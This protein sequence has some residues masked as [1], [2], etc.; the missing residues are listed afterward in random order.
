MKYVRVTAVNL[1]STCLLYLV[2]TAANGQSGTDNKDAVS[3]DPTDPSVIL[4]DITI[5]RAQR[6]SLLGL[7]PLKGAHD[8]FGNFSDMIYRENCVRVGVTFN[9]ASQ[10]IT[11]AVDDDAK[12]G[13]ATDMDLVAQ[14]DAYKRGEPTAGKLYVHIEGRWDYGTTG[15]QE[16]GFVS[17]AT[18]GG[19]AN[20]FAAY[21]PTFLPFR[22]LYWEQGSKEAG[23]A[24]RIGKITPDAILAT[25]QYISPV[26]TFLPNAGTGLFVSGYPDSGLGI[27]AVRHPSP[28]WRFLGLVSDAN[29]DRQNFGDIGAKDFYKAVEI[30]FKQCPKTDKA[31]YSKITF[32]HNDGT[33]DRQPINASTGLP[34]H[35]VTVKLEQELDPKGKNVAVLRW[36]RSWNTGAIFRQQAGLSFIFNNPSGPVGMQN[37][38]MGAAVNWVESVVPTAREEVNFEL[39]YRFPLFVGLDTTFSIQHIRNPAFTDE[40]N[41]AQAFSIR[42]RSVF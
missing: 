14:W 27:V 38:M 42:I 6:D 2:A 3:S 26:T 35:G 8:A 33:K 29:G 7:S 32:W 11:E 36:G 34:G 30:G 21:T 12:S 17:M 19:T 13:S 5:R 15:P 10:G 40:F 41:E 1:L 16:L 23:W 24:Y 39:F 22:N 20:A 18:A 31:G 25:S 4:P 37:D 28:R 9:H